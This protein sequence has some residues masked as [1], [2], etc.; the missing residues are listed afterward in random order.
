GAF[1]GNISADMLADLGCT[2]AIVG[3]SERRQYHGE[4]DATVAAKA[5]AAIEAGLV[6]IICV[7]ETEAARDTGRQNQIVGDQ[8]K[9]SLPAGAD[10]KNTVVAYEPVWAIGTGKTASIDDIRDMHA[11]I[12]TLVGDIKILYGGSVKGDNAA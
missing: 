6:A 8:I 9:G 7:G 5:K 4:T 3:H 1:T 10:S 12:R 2:H 11:F